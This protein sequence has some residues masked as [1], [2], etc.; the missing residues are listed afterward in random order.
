M[1]L[2]VFVGGIGKVQDQTKKL[3]RSSLLGGSTSK[4]SDGS[5]LLLFRSCLGGAWVKC[6]IRMTQEGRNHTK[7][8]RFF[9]GSF[10]IS[11]APRAWD[12]SFT[13]GALDIPQNILSGL[14]SIDNHLSAR[15]ISQSLLP[16]QV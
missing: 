3:K 10:L 2:V 16:A 9:Y 7:G 13:R 14:R 8:V 4:Q 1:T 12:R 6:R 15:T 5:G 11:K